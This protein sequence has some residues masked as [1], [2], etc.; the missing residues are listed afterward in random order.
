MEV[1]EQFRDAI[2]SDVLGKYFSKFPIDTVVGGQVVKILNLQAAQ[3]HKNE[4]EK[5]RIKLK[6]YLASQSKSSGEAQYYQHAGAQILPRR[7]NDTTSGTSV[8][9][10]ASLSELYTKYAYFKITTADD[11][12][13]L[14]PDINIGYTTV[15]APPEVG[16]N[17]ITLASTGEFDESAIIT[18]NNWDVSW[19]RKS[20]S[21]IVFT[22]P[23]GWTNFTFEIYER[24]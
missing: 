14:D 20:S 6:K 5:L 9:S 4:Y 10:L 21:E 11:Q 15:T 18:I 1:S 2:E 19:V 23:V 13:E 3:L 16:M 22:L 7:P 12:L 8:L 24:V 17:T